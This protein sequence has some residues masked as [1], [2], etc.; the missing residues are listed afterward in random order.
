M[1]SGVGRRRSKRRLPKVCLDAVVYGE[2]DG[3]C[4]KVAKHGGTEASVK[5]TEPVLS[6]NFA[7][8][9]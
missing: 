9:V 6:E 5:A 4:R 2:I 3:P 1:C 7:Y 8:G